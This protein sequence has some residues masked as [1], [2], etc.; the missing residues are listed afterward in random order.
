MTKTE[1]DVIVVGGG[2]AGAICASYLAKAGI[3]VLLADKAYFPR[4]KV[5]GDTLREGFVSHVNN[6]EAIEEI[7]SRSAC[8]RNMKI[9]SSAGNEAVVPFE[10]YTLPRRELDS[11]MLDT[12]GKWGVEVMQGCRFEDVIVEDGY[13][14]GIRAVFR[15][16]ETELRSKIV[17]GADGAH[18]SV[19]ASLGIM[20][21]DAASVY[22]GARAYFSDV[23]LDEQL[24]SGQYDAYGIA[25]FDRAV[26]PCCIRVT[27]VGKAGV[28]D[29]ICNVMITLYDRDSYRR[30]DFAKLFD[31]WLRRNEKAAHMF[32]NAVLIGGWKRG[33]LPCITQGMARCGNGY[34][35]AGD[36]ASVMMPMMLDGLSAAADSAGAAAWAASEAIRADDCS[37]ES[38]MKSYLTA[39]RK[40][41]TAELLIPGDA[42]TARLKEIDL[43]RESM[44]D[45][46]V[47]DDVVEKLNTDQEYMERIIKAF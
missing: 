8:I 14:R 7:D 28:G 6:L 4:D 38:M 22:I 45:S 40:S 2:P 43:I 5:C 36:A 13:V 15:G 20:K 25:A 12:A 9:I 35:L 3:D 34:L 33:K 29:G 26:A 21:E 37:G 44:Y 47:M 30:I 1:R 24:A 18:S 42:L 19:A 10:C 17:I 41:R 46:G 23:M 27:P 39:A 31:G 11:I 16:E 32:E